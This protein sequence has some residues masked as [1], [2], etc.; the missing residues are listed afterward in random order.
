M[1]NIKGVI[2]T[3][4]TVGVNVENLD[5][6]SA[7]LI[8]TP[9]VT[10]GT[11]ISGITQGQV[12]C[13]TSPKDAN[14]Y[15]IDEA[16]DKDNDVLTF[17]HISE[18]FRMAGNGT[19]LYF[20]AVPE[21]TTPAT[22]MANYGHALVDGADGEIR[23]LGVPFNSVVSTSYN[24]TSVNGLDDLVSAAI[25]AAQELATWADSKD[26]PFH[27]IL[28]GF[29][30]DVSTIASL[31]NLRDIQVSGVTIEYEK[32]SI[33]IGQDWKYADD[34]TGTNKNCADLGTALGT[35]SKIQ[36]NYNIGEVGENSDDNVLNLQDTDQAIWLVA[37]L[38]D[39][40]KITAKG[41][42][43]QN[44]EDLGYIFP[45]SYTGVTGYRWNND[46]VCAPVVIDAKGIMNIHTM[47]MSATRNKLA[48]KIRMAM[49]PYVKRTVQLDTKTGLLPTG[50]VKYYE[51]LANTPFD[52]ML[53]AGEIS[54]GEATVDQK[55]NL[56]SGDKAL[57]IGWAFVPTGT[58]G[59]IDGTLS[60][61][62]SL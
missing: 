6:C 4:G 2:I 14:N 59:E 34:L 30:V 28:E 50:M 39:H 24:Q 10:A 52:E 42:I 38:S 47:A 58:V 9:G 25:P 1:S 21:D 61:K 35:R 20:M 19:K 53:A 36:C 51:G 11:G 23:Y 37:G 54:G 32:V 8:N 49:L 31:Q 7:L 41:D 18:F 17:R 46:H 15:G 3:D 26:K 16:Y 22:A 33:C 5:G 27:V 57:N 45:L 62:Q 44:L 60:I 29:N 12:Y 48:R 55:S 13:F 40:S 43:L 56:L